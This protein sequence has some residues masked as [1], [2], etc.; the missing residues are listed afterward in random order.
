MNQSFGTQRY[1]A[2]RKIFKYPNIIIYSGVIHGQHLW[3]RTDRPDTSDHIDH[4]AVEDNLNASATTKQV[5]L[6]M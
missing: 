3:R 5:A 1:L 4:L 6:N 2:G